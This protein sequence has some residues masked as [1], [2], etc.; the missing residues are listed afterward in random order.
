MKGWNDGHSLEIPGFVRMKRTKDLN[1][2]SRRTILP[3]KVA[4]AKSIIQRLNGG[5]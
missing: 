3:Y 4:L 1:E 5:P 2:M